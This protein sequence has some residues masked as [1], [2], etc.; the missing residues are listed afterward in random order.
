MV[1]ECRGLIERDVGNAWLAGDGESSPLDDLI[2]HWC[3]AL[4]LAQRVGDLLP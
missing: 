3:A 2:G 1:L 4:R